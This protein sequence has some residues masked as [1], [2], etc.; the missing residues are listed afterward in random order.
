MGISEI[1]YDLPDTDTDHEWVELYN[2]GSSGVSLSGW[3]FNDGSS[4]ILNEPP[5]NG[6][7][8]SITIGSG[9]Y[10]ILA[11]NAT[12]FLADHPG[13]TGSVVDTVMSLGN[14]SDTLSLLDQNGTT[15]DTVSYASSQGGAGDGN[16]LQKNGSSWVS[17]SPTPGATNSTIAVADTQ[18]TTENAT[19]DEKSDVEDFITPGYTVEILAKQVVPSGVPIDFDTF[20]KDEKGN[21]ILPGRY[22][23]N[24]GDGASLSYTGGH[25]FTHVYQYPGTYIVLVEYANNTASQ[26]YDDSDRLTITVTDARIL[27]TAFNQ[28]G[29]ISIKNNSNY[30][31]DISGW[32]LKTNAHVYIFPKNS[33]L[34]ALGSLTLSPVV[35]GLLYAPSLSLVT[36]ALVSADMWPH[37]LV[38][39][40]THS[41]VTT[42]KSSEK[43][44]T[45]LAID[46]SS[47][48]ATTLSANV[49][50]STGS[51]H[52]IAVIGLL[53]L[54]VFAAGGVWFMR[55]KNDVDDTLSADDITIIE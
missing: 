41:V 35:T 31:T 39:T 6:G 2:D 30:E 45:P 38:A 11:G 48:N 36:P 55:T 15:L 8:G 44:V 37:S 33:F 1:M 43:D 54:C 12:V 5:A 34:G 26:T 52:T 9:G 22:D 24:F 50:H 4:H 42:K 3:K 18:S 40:T 7:Q 29:S 23:W 21:T 16:S 46:V 27:I 19:T 53:L 14:S 17:A 49:I 32:S 25:P 51:S 47:V 28:D 13:F 20:V 10:V